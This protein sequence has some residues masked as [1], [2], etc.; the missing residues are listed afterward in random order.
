MRRNKKI[1]VIY[2]QDCL[3]GFGSAWSAWR[4]FR[5][6]A[7]YWPSQPNPDKDPKLENLKEAEIFLI[8]VSF[9]AEKIRRLRAAGNRV[10]AIDHHISVRKDIAAADWHSFDLKHSAAVLAWLY[11]HPKKPVPK[12][13]RYIEDLDLWLFKLPRS[14]A[15]TAF[16]EL[17][18]KNFKK[19]NKLA[20]DFEKAAVRQKI[21]NQGEVILAAKEK[22]IGFIMANAEKIFF[23]GHKSLAVNSPFWSSEIGEAIYKKKPPL[24]IVWFKRGRFYKVSL[25]SNGGADVAALA[26]KYGGGGHKKAAGF[27]WPANKPL[28]WKMID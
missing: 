23:G 3:D 16:L 24:G 18:E 20:S 8:D 7:V 27:R 26:E 5:D 12:L 19:W 14:R 25:R 17:A 2:H 9:S 6:K 15:A 4:L 11:F 28:P 10:F 22:L 21:L 1:V 13:L